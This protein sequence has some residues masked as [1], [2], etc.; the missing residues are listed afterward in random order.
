LKSFSFVCGLGAFFLLWQAGAYLVGSEIILPGPLP[1]AAKLASLVQTERFQTALA[2]TS[3]R[4]LAGLAISVPLGVLAGLVSA[5]SGRAAAFLRP[6]FSVIAA[7]PVMSVILIAFLAFGA[8]RTPVFTAFLMVFPVIAANTIAGARAVDPNLLEMFRVYYP[9]R[10]E[11]LRY[12]YVP[13]LL[14][15]LAA[16]IRSALSLGWKVTVAA[17]VLVQPLFALGTGMQM[18]KAQLETPELF[19]WTVATVI[20]AALSDLLLDAPGLLFGRRK[21]ILEKNNGMGQRQTPRHPG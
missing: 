20:A 13:S 14:P 2:R 8:E 19:A 17:E 4:L 7:T 10:V 6:F 16:G 18:A 3:L 12:L 1:V 11:K 5:L 15:Y 21:I 9:R